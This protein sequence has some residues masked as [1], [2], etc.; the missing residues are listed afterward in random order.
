MGFAETILA[1]N[2]LQLQWVTSQDV[3][4][5]R[6][7]LA[8]VS[9]YTVNGQGLL[10]GASALDIS[11]DAPAPGHGLYYLVKPPCCGSWLTITG[12]GG[13]RDNQLP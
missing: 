9:S 11:V 13:D 3:S 5:V 8:L 6:G 7:E 1:P 4:W 12:T 10:I 2:T